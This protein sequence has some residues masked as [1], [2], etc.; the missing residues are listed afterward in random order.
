MSAIDELNEL[1][2][3]D[4]TANYWEN[5]IALTARTLVGQLA[6]ADWRTLESGWKD[7][8]ADWR[9]RLADVLS[10]GDPG[11]TVPI[12]VPMI[13]TDDDELALT[14]AD[15]LNAVATAVK[16]SV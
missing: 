16:Y 14:A 12:L 4:Y 9:R 11:R 7:H 3:G 15:S 10:R 2:S 5:D 6:D 13:E 8:E 1:L